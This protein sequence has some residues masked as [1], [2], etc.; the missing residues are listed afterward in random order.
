MLLHMKHVCNYDKNNYIL[1][2]RIRKRLP[3]RVYSEGVGAAFNISI[4]KILDK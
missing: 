4:C 3:Y 2:D 1:N